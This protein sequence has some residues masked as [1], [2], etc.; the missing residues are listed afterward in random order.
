MKSP[1]RNEFKLGMNQ[2]CKY[3]RFLFFADDDVKQ[4]INITIFTHPPN[5]N[6]KEFN[7]ALNRNLYKL[8]RDLGFRKRHIKEGSSLE[9]QQ[10]ER[11]V[12]GMSEV[13]RD[14]LGEK[15]K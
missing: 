15:Y 7:L 11:R 10:W 4:V 1:I 3:W 5:K 6:L 14:I 12:I 9:G 8:A 13:N 2:A